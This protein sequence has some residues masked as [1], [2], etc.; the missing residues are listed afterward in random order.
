MVSKFLENDLWKIQFV[1]FDFDGVFTDNTVYVDENGTESVRCWRGDGLGL[2][3]LRELDVQLAVVSTEPNPVVQK[4]CKKLKIQ[5]ISACDDKASAVMKLCKDLNVPLANTCFIGNDINDVP[6]L[7]IVGFPII[8]ND[9][10]P[11]LFDLGALKM[12]LQGGRGVVREL[13]ERI[14][15]VKNHKTRTNS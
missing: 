12:R 13:C 14:V 4:R 11:S 1:I 3:M 5:C 6:A 7:K 9:S 8:T 15:E 2:D 10:D